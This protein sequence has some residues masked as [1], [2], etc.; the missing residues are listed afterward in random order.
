MQHSPKPSLSIQAI[1][2]TFGAAPFPIAHTHSAPLKPHQRITSSYA[3]AFVR[4][5]GGCKRTVG[6]SSPLGCRW[7]PYCFWIFLHPSDAISRYSED[8]APASRHVWL[9]Q[10]LVCQVCS[11]FLA[12]L[13]H[14]WVGRLET[15]N[16]LLA[17]MM[18]G[19]QKAARF[20]YSSN[21]WQGL[22]PRRM[23]MLS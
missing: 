17:L 13:F 16:A 5:E 23:F 21:V 7:F 14:L 15:S 6:S 20:G 4:D 2:G 10:E 22:W 9:V 12:L 11:W 8:N 18:I 1:G 19:T 3:R